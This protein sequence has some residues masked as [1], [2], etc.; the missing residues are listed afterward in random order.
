MLSR[1]FIVISLSS[2]SF[3]SSFFRFDL[4]QV[5]VEAVVGLGDYLAVKELFAAARFIA[6]A[7]NEGCP[8]R[9]EGEQETPYAAL[10]LNSFMLA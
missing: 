2:S 5:R 10:N 6:A 8:V 7:K 9:I 1:V 4:R 3:S